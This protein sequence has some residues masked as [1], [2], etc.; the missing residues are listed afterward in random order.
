MR[1]KNVAGGGGENVE[2][3]KKKKK[4]D[5][6]FTVPGFNWVFIPLLIHLICQEV[7][8]PYSEIITIVDFYIWI[9]G[10]GWWR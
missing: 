9:P 4:K 6:N 8:L 10:S 1:K 5:T 2:Q 7:L 3:A